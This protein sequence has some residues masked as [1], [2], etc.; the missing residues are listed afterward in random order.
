MVNCWGKRL[1]ILHQPGGGKKKFSFLSQRITANTTKQASPL[2]K[3]RHFQK[4]F[5]P[6]IV[7]K[8]ILFT[9]LSA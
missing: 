3:Y 7:D 2:N 8:P 4:C 5:M 9:C 1:K 6:K